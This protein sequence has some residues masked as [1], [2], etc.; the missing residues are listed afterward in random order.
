MEIEEIE[1]RYIPHTEGEV[2][3]LRNIGELP[4]A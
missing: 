4:T 3:P 2:E 1:V